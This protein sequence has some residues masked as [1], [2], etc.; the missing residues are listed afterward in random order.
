MDIRFTPEQERWRQ[1]VIAFLREEITP[2]FIDEMEAEDTRHELRPRG[3]L[4]EA[5]REGLAHA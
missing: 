4:E 5:G 1:E 3:L 2:A